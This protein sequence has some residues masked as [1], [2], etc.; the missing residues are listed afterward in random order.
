MAYTQTLPNGN[1]TVWNEVRLPDGRKITRNYGTYSN[2]HEAQQRVH[3]VD[4]NTMPWE[5]PE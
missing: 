3:Q 5:E 2:D 1:V 4:T